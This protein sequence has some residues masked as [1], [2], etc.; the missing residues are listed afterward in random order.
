M[1]EE[2][3]PEK[4]F[5]PSPK[6]IT[7]EDRVFQDS[8]RY[9]RTPG[10]SRA[11]TAEHTLELL[12]TGL[13]GRGVFDITLEPTKKEGMSLGS[14]TCKRRTQDGDEDLF[15]KAFYATADDHLSDLKKIADTDARKQI[16]PHLACTVIAQEL[17]AEL[18]EELGAPLGASL[19]GTRVAPLCFV[20]Y[21]ESLMT[22]VVISNRLDFIAYD[23]QQDKEHLE[24]GRGSNYKRDDKRWQ[25]FRQ[26]A[27]LME[28][29]A[30]N[31]GGAENF[32]K[33][34]LRD[35]AACVGI[36]EVPDT[37]VTTNVLDPREPA[38]KNIGLVRRD[39]GRLDF[40]IVDITEIW[41]AVE[42]DVCKEG[43]QCFTRED[44]I[45]FDRMIW[46]CPAFDT[47]ERRRAGL[48]F[49]WAM[50]DDGRYVYIEGRAASDHR[51]RPFCDLPDALRE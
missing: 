16:L 42:F 24:G 28:S 46:N 31:H 8:K 11:A 33:R 35:F 2:G 14:G 39:D 44:I 49:W 45:D 23:N 40:G 32:I 20:V 9:P 36:D 3:T 50:L 1:V 7:P 17:G 12:R 21:L 13:K 30:T 25:E 29:A 5:Q 26:A 43:P 51:R 41:H 22:A 6:N 18:G 19:G 4:V 10:D 15:W 37:D 38:Y 34:H 47:D 27:K 48:D